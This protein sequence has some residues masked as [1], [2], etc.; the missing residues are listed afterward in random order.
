MLLLLTLIKCGRIVR[1][2]DIESL[3]PGGLIGDKRYLANE[4]INCINCFVN[5]SSYRKNS[6][7]KVSNVTYCNKT[8]GNYKESQLSMS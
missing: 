1:K 7:G 6:D 2:M 5:V 3:T 8:P 4:W